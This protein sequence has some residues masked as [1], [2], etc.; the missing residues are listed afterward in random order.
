[1]FLTWKM[2]IHLVSPL[3]FF[4]GL[5]WYISEGSG[6]NSGSHLLVQVERGRRGMGGVQIVTGTG[7]PAR[8]SSPGA[9]WPP[10]LSPQPPASGQG[11]C[12]CTSEWLS[13]GI[14]PGI[15]TPTSATICAGKI[16]SLILQTGLL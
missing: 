10:Q 11:L 8:A 14:L 4:R 2:G 16:D 1:M 3:W 6:A 7:G 15:I 9:L 5:S 12:C 13:C